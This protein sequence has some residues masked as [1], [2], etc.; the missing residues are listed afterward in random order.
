MRFANFYRRFIKGYS[1]IA[2]PLINLIKKD[3]T[4][5]WTENEQL[6]FEKL[7]RRFSKT[8][9]LAVFDPELLIIIKTDASD[10]AIGACIM[11]LKKER[12]FYPFAFYSRKM[13]SAELNYDIHDKELLTIVAAFQE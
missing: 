4:F 10:Y 7:K 3:R 12:K 1:G 11:Q 13:L 5:A 2:T 6:V 8:P 9:I